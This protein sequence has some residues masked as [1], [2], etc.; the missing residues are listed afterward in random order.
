MLV[1]VEDGARLYCELLGGGPDKPLIIVHHG[2]PGVSSH[3]E[4]KAS[5]GFLTDRFR[6]LVFDARGS[7]R[8]DC[9]G[10]YTHER[11]VADVEALRCRAGAETIVI[12]GGSYGG[13]IALEYTLAFPERVAAIILRDTSAHG[14]ILADSAALAA[15]SNRVRVDPERLKRMFAGT[16]IDDADMEA[17][18]MEIAPL[19]AGSNPPAPSPDGAGPALGTNRELIFH[20][21]TH[22]AAFSQ[23]LG[24]YDVRGRLGEIRVPVLVTV[25]RHDWITPVPCSE[26]IASGIPE[27]ELVVFE[28]SG[29]SPPADEPE[30]FQRTVRSFIDRVLPEVAA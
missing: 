8:S 11:W 22:N 15:R 14:D 2:G 10:P 6:V 25:G 17:C 9:I 20:A 16:M 7:G 3:A 29:H 18:L 13:F 24:R 12:A 19:Y 1:E 27:A 26:E 5:F 23:T 30:A 4:S 21:A 28:H